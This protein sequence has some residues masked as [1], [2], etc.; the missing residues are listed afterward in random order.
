MFP[1]LKPF[2]VPMVA[3]ISFIDEYTAHNL[4]ENA[5]NEGRIF[6]LQYCL[7]LLAEGI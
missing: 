2:N 4:K 3:Y 6:Q 7:F 5:F 1:Y